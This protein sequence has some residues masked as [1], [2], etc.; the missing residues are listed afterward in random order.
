MT[1]L[2]PKGDVEEE[3]EGV[4]EVEGKELELQRGLVLLGGAVALVVVEEDDQVVVYGLFFVC[5]C[6]YMYIG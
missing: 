1:R 5:I 3:A 4:D 6:I 2:E